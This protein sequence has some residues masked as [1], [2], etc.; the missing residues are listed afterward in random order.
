[1]GHIEHSLE[2]NRCIPGAVFVS[3]LHIFPILYY[4]FFLIL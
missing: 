1:M 4:L 3:A 2:S